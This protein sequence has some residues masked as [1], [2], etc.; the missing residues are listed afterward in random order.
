M[1]IDKNYCMSSFLAF[2]YIVREDKDF[3]FG[4][5]H[6]HFVQ[7]PDSKKVPVR[8]AEEIDEALK[9]QFQSLSGEKL[10]ILLSGGMDSAIL[11]AYMPGCD[12]YTF[13]FLGGDYQKEELRRAEYYAKFYGLNLHYIDIDW[14][15]VLNSVDPVMQTKQAPVHSIE[16]QIYA[17]ALQAKQD[18]ITRMVIG[19]ASDY[20]F[21]GMDKLLSKD[22]TFEEFYNRFIYID[23]SEVLRE[24]VD[25]KHVFE[26][27]RRGEYVD[28]M[29]M[30]DTI[31]VD[32]SYSSYENAFLAAQMPYVDPYETLKMADSLDL[33][34]VRIGE[35]KY[36]I[37]EL[38][39]MK[40]PDFPVPE[41]VPMPRPVDLYFKDWNGPERPEFRDD[42]DMSKFTGNQKWLLWCLE[43]FLKEYC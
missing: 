28:F 6:K 22:W 38:F 18:G 14:Q 15:T 16:P 13:R 3:A 26:P 41:K 29:G 27:F 30:M 23:P 10:G 33:S 20:V 19:D 36:L 34:R 2:R 9:A 11:A 24:P 39:R 25:M 1:G 12:A 8:T 40:Y 35:S 32:E 7:I 4:M 31:T 43:R 42:L 5:R 37:R 21:G 17:G